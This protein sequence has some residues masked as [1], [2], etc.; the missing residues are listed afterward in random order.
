MDLDNWKEIHAVFNRL[1]K[2]FYDY[3]EGVDSMD[4]GS[5][6]LT[7]KKKSFIEIL[8]INEITWIAA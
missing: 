7:L 5:F 3:V 8:K 2:N 4:N 1:K 6:K